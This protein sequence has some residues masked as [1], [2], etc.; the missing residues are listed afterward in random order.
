[1]IQKLALLLVLA[2]STT[3]SAEEV[4][5]NKKFAKEVYDSISKVAK[6]ISDLAIAPEDLEIKI[7][8]S[9]ETSFLVR[10]TGEGYIMDGDSYMANVS[11]FTRFRRE[12][13]TS[14]WKIAGRS[15]CN[16]DLFYAEE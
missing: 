13:A 12:D 11:C 15:R 7:L 3:S 14:P 10:T 6:K 1:V 8:R 2:V 9:R 16:F 5:L 4:K